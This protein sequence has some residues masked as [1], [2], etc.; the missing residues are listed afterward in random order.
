[1]SKKQH[2]GHSE[3]DIGSDFLRLILTADYIIPIMHYVASRLRYN[4]VIHFDS[5]M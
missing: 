1:M 5:V 2:T 4:P 3:S